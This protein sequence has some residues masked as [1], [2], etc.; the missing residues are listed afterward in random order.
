M[1]PIS[2]AAG[3]RSDFGRKALKGRRIA[4]LAFPNREYFP[5]GGRQG[6]PVPLIARA[7]AGDFGRP[8]GRIRFHG[9][10]AINAARAAMPKAPMDKNASAPGRKHQVRPPGKVAAMQ[11]IA[12]ACSV[13]IAAH[14]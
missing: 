1:L 14:G 8:I 9:S 4:R 11:A 6:L 2:G 7:V 12:E 3:Q 13:K 5:S 10:L